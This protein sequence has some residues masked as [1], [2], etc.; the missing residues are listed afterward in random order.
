MDAGLVGEIDGLKLFWSKDETISETGQSS[1]LMRV[2]IMN[3][4]F[5]EDKVPNEVL[6][7]CLLHEIANIAVDFGIDIIERKRGVANIMAECPGG[8]IARKWLNQVMI[9]I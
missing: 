8:E 5:K 4:R 3:R 9:G 6:D 2:V 7:Y 1:C